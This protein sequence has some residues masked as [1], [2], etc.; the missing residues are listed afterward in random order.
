MTSLQ[1]SD[2]HIT[3]PEKGEARV[4]DVVVDGHVNK[5]AA[6]YHPEPEEAVQQI[7]NY[8]S[9]WKGILIEE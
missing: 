2:T 1:P 9:F 8:I 5:D 6:W 4:Y 3:T 7:R